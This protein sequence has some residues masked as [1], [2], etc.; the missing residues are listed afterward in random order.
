MK[1]KYAKKVKMYIFHNST[2]YFMDNYIYYWSSSYKDRI[3][4]KC[5]HSKCP[6][7]ITIDCKNK[8][9]FI[10]KEHRGKH[11]PKTSIPSVDIKN[12]VEDPIAIGKVAINVANTDRKTKKAA[13]DVFFENSEYA[14]TFAKDAV[15]KGFAISAY[16]FENVLTSLKES[17]KN[18]P[19]LL[20]MIILVE[21]HDKVIK[22]LKENSNFIERSQIFTKG[23]KDNE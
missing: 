11:F 13:I 3:Y 12:F 9:Y 20:K 23:I 17:K 6:S 7:R 14:N 18:Y 15:D 5:S 1:I 21:S 19:T 16:V 22:M 2:S 4:F 10:S 8:T